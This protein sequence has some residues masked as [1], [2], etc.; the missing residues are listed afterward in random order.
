MTTPPPFHLPR[1]ARSADSNAG[2]RRTRTAPTSG[3]GPQ[4]V[5]NNR[6]RQ[7]GGFNPTLG[8]NLN[9]AKGAPQAGTPSPAPA[10]GP[11]APAAGRGTPGASFMSNEDI[12]AFS[13]HLRKGARNRAVERAMDA[14][15][16]EAVLRHI[17]TQDGSM[18]GARLRAR[19]VS[20]HL[21]KIAK[22]EQAIAKAAA[23]LYAQFEQEYE[24]NLRK[25][26]KARGPQPT[27][28]T[29]GAS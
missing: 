27:R 9:F 17:P 19:R 16:L 8:L 18:G 22:A 11:G 21:K 10:A 7:G 23:A 4:S 13:E 25:V 24:A 12:R 5:T 20:R 15:Q 1:P 6:T 3:P 29:F 14:E 28:F 2:P 26:G